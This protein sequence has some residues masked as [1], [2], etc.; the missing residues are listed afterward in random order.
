MIGD[1]DHGHPN[2]AL[3]CVG[4]SHTARG[5]ARAS[6]NACAHEDG[7]RDAALLKRKTK[8]DLIQIVQSLARQLGS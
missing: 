8:K 4:T 5:Q 6:C 2:T 7:L 1:G 3:L